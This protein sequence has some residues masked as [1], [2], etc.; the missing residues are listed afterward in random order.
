MAHVMSDFQDQPLPSFKIPPVIET[1]LGVQ[2][3]PLTELQS[4]HL[5]ALWERMFRAE[6]PLTEDRAPLDPVVETYGAP[7]TAIPRLRLQMVERPPVPRCWFVKADG[8]ELVQVQQDRFI[9]NWR[10]RGERDEYPRYENIRLQFSTE[11]EKF[12]EFLTDEGFGKI[13]ANQWE[14]TYV[15]HVPANSIF[16]AHGEIKK[17]ISI[18]SMNFSDN[19]LENPESIQFS[20]RHL[21]RNDAGEFIGRLHITAQPV[22][23]TQDDSP[24]IILTLTARGKPLE[25]SFEGILSSL[26]LGRQYVVRGFASITTKEAHAVWEREDVS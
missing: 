7:Q 4:C 14:V 11:M 3:D 13:H 2:F 24:L 1:V 9:H 6:F 19:F 15:N 26:D 5:G 21:I 18:F 16:S 22:F 25:D 17:L 20:G 23:R 10:K 8:S 12:Q